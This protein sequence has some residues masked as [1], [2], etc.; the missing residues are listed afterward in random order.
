MHISTFSPSPL[1][2]FFHPTSFFH[3]L[4]S[5]RKSA[6]CSSNL[7][8]YIQPVSFSVSSLI[9][10]T[11]GLL[12]YLLL[13]MSSGKHTYTNTQTHTRAHNTVSITKCLQLTTEHTKQLGTKIL[14]E[15]VL[16]SK[17][18]QTSRYSTHTCIHTHTYIHY[19][20]I[21]GITP[22]S[23]CVQVWSPSP[24]MRG[25][26]IR[27]AG[28][29][30]SHICLYLSCLHACCHCF[31]A[32]TCIHSLQSVLALVKL[33]PPTQIYYI[34]LLSPFPAILAQALIASQQIMSFLTPPSPH[35]LV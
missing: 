31:L 2:L 25:M 1:N 3:P 17:S 15:C 24:C 19:H 16:N 18:R 22:G 28:C 33:L 27:R 5:H 6:N 7:T 20:C 35:F 26:L 30:L 9:E 21:A 14:P 4:F 13:T 32:S 8:W 11:L 34:F 29:Q 23:G 12:L 10:A